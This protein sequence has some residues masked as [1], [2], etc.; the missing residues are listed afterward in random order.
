MA[1]TDYTTLKAAIVRRLHRSDLTAQ[2]PDYIAL[3][4]ARFA[5][6]LRVRAMEAV[7]TVVFA[8]GDASKALPADFLE[9][10]SISLDSA[11]PVDMRYVTPQEIVLPASDNGQSY[12]YTIIG[13]DLYLAPVPDGGATVRIVYY[14]RPAALSDANPA[15]ALLTAACDVYL[16]GALLESI[17]DTQQTSMVEIWKTFYQESVAKL[18]RA[19]DAARYTSQLVARPPRRI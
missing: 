11:V 15:N 3:A 6:D 10:R 9:L 4:E 14:A 17:P 13:D 2:I 18:Q 5:R 7:G 12:Y 16:Y 1:I 19:E 8:A